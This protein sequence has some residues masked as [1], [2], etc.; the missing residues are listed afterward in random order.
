M[1]LELKSM[2]EKAALNT[3]DAL[4]KLVRYEVY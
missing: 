2:L 3:S 4:K 1:I